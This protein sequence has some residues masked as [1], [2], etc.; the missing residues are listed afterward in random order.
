MTTY[1]L[2]GLGL[3]EHC[4]T[5]LSLEGFPIEA[6]DAEWY[7]PKCQGILGGKSF[8]YE[9]KGKE[10]K[11]AWWVGTDGK[12]TRTKPTEDFDIGNWHIIIRPRIL[13]GS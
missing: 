11:K 5:L 2:A 1:L 13:Y 6:I 3:C 10:A 12:W 9:G 8:G 7:C 4:E